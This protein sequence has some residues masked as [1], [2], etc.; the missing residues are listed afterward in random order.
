MG[1]RTLTPQIMPLPKT[2]LIDGFGLYCAL[3]AKNRLE[4]STELAKPRPIRLSYRPYQHRKHKGYSN[5]NIIKNRSNR[6]YYYGL[7]Q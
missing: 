4:I 5:D 1:S 3:F 6:R 2:A 7:C